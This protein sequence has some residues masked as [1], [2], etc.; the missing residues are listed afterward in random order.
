[1]QISANVFPGYPN[2][3]LEPCSKELSRLIRSPKEDSSLAVTEE[4]GGRVREKVMTM[5][6]LD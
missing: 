1:M 2:L 5:N 3:K 4:V 6:E